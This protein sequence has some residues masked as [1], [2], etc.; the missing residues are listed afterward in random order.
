MSVRKQLD[1]VDRGFADL[2]LVTTFDRCI[3]HQRCLCEVGGVTLSCLANH[4]AE[5]VVHAERCESQR[6][7]FSPRVQESEMERSPAEKRVRMCRKCGVP[8]K[9]HKCPLRK[10]WGSQNHQDRSVGVK[11]QRKT[12]TE[13]AIRRSPRQQLQDDASSLPDESLTNKSSLQSKK[14]QSQ[15]RT[16]RKKRKVSGVNLSEA[17]DSE[18]DASSEFSSPSTA[19]DDDYDIDENFLRRVEQRG[20]QQ[21]TEVLAPAHMLQDETREH[22]SEHPLLP[23]ASEKSRNRRNERRFMVQWNNAVQ[24]RLHEQNELIVENRRLVAERRKIHRQIRQ[25]RKRLVTLRSRIRRLQS[26]TQYLNDT[27]LKERHQNFREA[28]VLLLA[29]DDT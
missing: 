14:K 10:R 1:T 26:N 12:K 19:Q 24:I 18:D 2:Q 6:L 25:E 7:V 29:L 11:I 13:E 23:G 16:K 5:E 20:E 9:G 3:G 15:S 22:L 21:W 17:L 28:S 27:K 4:T 8:F